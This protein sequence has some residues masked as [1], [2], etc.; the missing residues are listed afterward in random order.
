MYAQGN[1]FI[2]N[3]WALWYWRGHRGKNCAMK[4]AWFVSIPVENQNNKS[5]WSPNT[6]SESQHLRALIILVKHPLPYPL[7]PFPALYFT[8]PLSSLPPTPPLLS[9]ISQ[10]FSFDYFL[11]PHPPVLSTWITQ[12]FFLPLYRVFF[13]PPLKP[14]PMSSTLLPS[15]NHAHPLDSR[16]TFK[17]RTIWPGFSSLLLYRH[18]DCISAPIGRIPSTNIW[19]DHVGC[20]L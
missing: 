12:V 7:F 4:S 3:I 16:I 10:I 6:S 17:D 18:I 9:L 1:L 8:F 20:F 14:L 11:L 19:E 13:T 2:S 5:T 15:S